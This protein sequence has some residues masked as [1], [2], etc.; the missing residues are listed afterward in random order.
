ML[1]QEPETSV[2]MILNR[3]NRDKDFEKVIK[4]HKTKI[5]DN[6]LISLNLSNLNLKVLS[7]DLFVG[8]NL[9]RL[10]ELILGNNKLEEIGSVFEPLTELSFLWLHNNI[11]KSIDFQFLNN[12]ELVALYLN[13]NK[14]EKIHTK[15]FSSLSNL[16]ELR[17][18]ENNL[19]IL[20]K[21]LF[22]NNQ[23][24]Q[25][26]T[27]HKN[28]IRIGWKEVLKLPLLE[29]LTLSELNNELI[30]NLKE[31]SVDLKIIDL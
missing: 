24:L 2:K 12:L 13:K 19:T 20:N 25:F 29:K 6:H 9:H 3:L 31:K 22:E 10:V 21:G 4:S 8:L 18:A 26:L 27:L 5:F 17:L 11:L 16:R 28:R 1:Y 23:K 7:D 15:A 14:L 30:E